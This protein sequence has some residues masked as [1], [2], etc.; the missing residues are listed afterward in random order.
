VAG[1]QDFALFVCYAP[2]DN[3]KYVVACVVE[4]GKGGAAAASPVSAE[5]MDTALKAQAGT[6]DVTLAPL[7]A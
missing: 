7:S 3:P 5:V 4:E 1:K 6:L 2:F